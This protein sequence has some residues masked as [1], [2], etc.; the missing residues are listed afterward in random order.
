MDIILRS[1]RTFFLNIFSEA[2]AGSLKH[3][4]YS[5]EQPHTKRICSEAAAQIFTVPTQNIHTVREDFHNLSMVMKT[6]LMEF[7]QKSN[8][9]V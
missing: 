5:Q 2:A 1:S 9:L 4:K 6:S 3:M 7:V 8:G